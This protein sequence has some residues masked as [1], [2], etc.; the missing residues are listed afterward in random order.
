MKKIICLMLICC[1]CL[2][3]VVCFSAQN[4]TQAQ[5]IENFKNGMYVGDWV[6]STLSEQTVK[7]M[8]DCGIQYTFLWAFR[9]DDPQKVQ[10]LEWCK[11]YGIKVILKD[12]RIYGDAMKDMT[13]QQIYEIIK[14]SIGDPSIIGYCIK[15]EP[16]EKEY[17]S[18][19]VCLEK[20][21]SVAQGM[22]PFVNL[23]GGIYGSYIDRVFTTLGQD[24]I[25]VDIYPLYGEVI[26]EN[27]FYNVK[28]IADGA[29]RHDI[30]FWMFIQSM[31]WGEAP[32]QPDINDMR[33]QGYTVLAFGATKITHFCYSNPLYYPTFDNKFIDTVA[34]VNNGVKSEQYDVLQQ[35]NREMQYL[36]PRL[37]LYKDLGTFRVEADSDE[38]MPAYMERISYCPQY[39]D[40]RTIKTISSNQFLL[41]GG[42]TGKTDN[43]K[44]AFVISNSADPYYGQAADVEFTL[45]Y[46]D[47]P[48]TVTMEGQ[49]FEIQ[50]D[51][52]GVY[53]IHLG[54]GGGAF[55]EVEER[56][57]TEDEVMIDMLYSDCYAVK[58]TYLEMAEDKTK[59]EETSYLNLESILNNYLDILDS[60]TLDIAELV[61]V[62][63][64]L[65]SAQAQVRTKLDIAL[66]QA[67]QVKTI[68]SQI[69]PE[70]FN[71]KGYEK[72]SGY[73]DMLSR[74]L[75]ASTVVANRVQSLV[76][77]I[78]IAVDNLEFIGLLG[79]M[80]VDG[81]V[82]LADIM[83]M[84]RYVSGLDELSYTAMR[85]GDFD[86]NLKLQLND[87]ILAAK[88]VLNQV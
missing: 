34:A 82:S 38:E 74:E 46:S 18:L 21:R 35:F 11:K 28:A 84:A 52:N 69:V 58:N 19:A 40:F 7:D 42:F 31:A 1:L 70:F 53:K 8:A 49:T 85:I 76:N 22:I 73:M 86:G 60:D 77:A 10:E 51:A 44:K 68:Y 5:V 25:S 33:F 61:A 75:N 12:N 56:A 3:F 87:I 63:D 30:D 78:L 71:E 15:D 65:Q 47:K 9:Y 23:Y 50:P 29:R 64:I 66:E 88:V 37:S 32:R 14:P 80:N 39:E 59:Y 41:V 6:P 62:R 72:I 2:S 67:E 26:Q 24:F 81:V 36:A 45:R 13:T 17:E 43:L 20:F 27:Y 48:V 79:D 57:R 54:P 4:L 16:G 83:K 55:V